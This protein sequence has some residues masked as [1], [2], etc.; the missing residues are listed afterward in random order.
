MERYGC[1]LRKMG[2]ED[3]A[4]ELDRRAYGIVGATNAPALGIPTEGAVIN[5]KAL[6][7]PK[8][9]YPDEAR[10]ARVAG[11][12]TVRLIIDERGKVIH[13]C[14][15]EGPALLMRAS[16]VAAYKAVFTPTK[17]SGQPVK[18]SGIVTY[19]FVPR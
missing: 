5:G 12:V 6:S 13:A 10:T 16:E 17:L 9:R 4:S 1:L 3:E 19:S 8:P 7:L 2:R 14:A 11:R 15:V 18:V